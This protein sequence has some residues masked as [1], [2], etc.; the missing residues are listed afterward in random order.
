[1]HITIPISTATALLIAL[2]HL[3]TAEA[4][5]IPN[6]QSPANPLTKR[7]RIPK[8]IN[9]GLDNSYTDGGGGDA[10]V[11]WVYVIPISVYKTQEQHMLIVFNFRNGADPCHKRSELHVVQPENP[12][13]HRFEVPDID[14]QYSM[15]GCGGDSLWLLRNGKDNVGTCYYAP[16]R[17]GCAAGRGFSGAWQC[18]LNDPT[19]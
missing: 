8:A 16:G 15:Q 18:L 4:L 1:M 17:I 11:V 6:N 14:F 10:Y 19:E 7:Q 3:S 2:Y 5:T 12:C 13:N 9:I